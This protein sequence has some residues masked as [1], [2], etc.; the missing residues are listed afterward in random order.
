MVSNK[1]QL[2]RKNMSVSVRDFVSPADVIASMLADLFETIENSSTSSSSKSANESGDASDIDFFIGK[3]SN[4]MKQK[5]IYPILQGRDSR[6]GREGYTLVHAASRIGNTS[7][8]AYLLD[9]G[10]DVNAVDNSR[11]LRTPLM[12]AVDSHN[13]SSA[14][15]LANRGARL[16]CEDAN[17]ENIFHYY[18]RSNNAKDLKQLVL[19]SQLGAFDVQALASKQAV[20]KKKPFP[21]NYAP[22]LSI[23]CDILRS[24]REQGAYLS[25]SDI[26]V[27]QKSADMDKN[28][29]RRTRSRSRG[30]RKGGGGVSNR[31]NQLN[32]SD[33]YLLQADGTNPNTGEDGMGSV[34]QQ[35]QSFSEFGPGAPSGAIPMA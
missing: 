32:S 17:G 7:L 21:E 10:A 3:C 20:L 5:G 16:E 6:R 9:N 19:A 14:T 8:L 28:G 29:R 1:P 4:Y 26:K 11:N 35:S 13:F 27:M 34:S 12:I 31:A 18:A 25:A 33:E 23:T 24:Y 30:G 15:L 2:R 22:P